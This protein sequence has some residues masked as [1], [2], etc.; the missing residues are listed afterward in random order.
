[1]SDIPAEPRE[2]LDLDEQITRIER[3]MAETRKF[4]AE[5]NKLGAEASKLTTERGTMLLEGEKFRA[6][7]FKLWRDWRMAPWIFGLT[8]IAG[9]V[10]G[11]I[12]KHL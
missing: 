10:G 12:G 1:M 5:Q 4:V 7:A 11:L 6:E 3:Q 2:R 8:L 9:A